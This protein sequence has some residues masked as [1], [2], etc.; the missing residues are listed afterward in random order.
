MSTA[1]KDLF[2]SWAEQQGNIS[3]CEDN[4]TA[5][6]SAVT[7]TRQTPF[8]SV[9]TTMLLLPDRYP[10]TAPAGLRQCV[11]LILQAVPIPVIPC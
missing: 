1:N 8:H 6:L 4:Q 10:I 5:V 2:V 7:Q 11:L 9:T 3:P